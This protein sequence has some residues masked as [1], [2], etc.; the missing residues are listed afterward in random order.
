MAQAALLWCKFPHLRFQDVRGKTSIFLGTSSVR[1]AAQLQCKFP[2]SGSSMYAN[3]APIWFFFIPGTSSVRR[4]AQLQCKFPR[5]RFQD[6]RGNLI[7]FYSRY[8]LSASC[9][10]AAMQVPPPPVPGC[11]R[12]PEH[13]TQEAGLRG[14]SLLSSHPS[15]GGRHQVTRLSLNFL[16]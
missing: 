5:L 6:V 10:A 16:R 14:G 8:Q 9:R 13:A 1:R 11:A 3:C 4:A 2:A 12:Q 15:G 7:L